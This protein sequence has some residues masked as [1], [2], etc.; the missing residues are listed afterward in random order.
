MPR[1]KYTRPH[2][3]G[4]NNSAH[5]AARNE[6]RAAA[7]VQAADATLK[8]LTSP[9]PAPVQEPAPPVT[10]P[11]Y[12]PSKGE[13]D[14]HRRIAIVW[15]YE[16][17]GCPPESEWGKHGG[18]MRQIADFLLMPDPCDYRPIRL[19]CDYRPKYGHLFAQTL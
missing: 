16:D 1:R 4:S 17:L 18:T 12:V 14:S 2:K 5:A 7:V 10:E 11:T 19:S 3:R 15:K 13:M 9:A 6:A 8:E